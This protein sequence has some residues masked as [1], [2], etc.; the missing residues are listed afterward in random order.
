MSPAQVVVVP[1]PYHCSVTVTLLRGQ[2]AVAGQYF[3]FNSLT[4]Q[5]IVDIPEAVKT[6]FCI[7]QWCCSYAYQLSLFSWLMSMYSKTAL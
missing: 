2:P 1:Y 7:N 6:D 4:L 3:V 5:Y